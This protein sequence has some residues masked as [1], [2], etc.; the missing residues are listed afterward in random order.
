MGYTNNKNVQVAEKTMRILNLS[1]YNA[2]TEPICKM[3]HIL[4]LEDLYKYR[5]MKFYY[6]LRTFNIPS[7]FAKCLETIVRQTSHN[8]RFQN[9]LHVPH[10]RI[11]HDFGKR[12]IHYN[13]IKITN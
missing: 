13:L 2:H 11:L 8:T 6:K 4:K 10:L 12:G 3:L 7:Y 9:E 1:N 5:M